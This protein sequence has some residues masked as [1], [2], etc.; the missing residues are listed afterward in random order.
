MTDL[1]SDI[2]HETPFGETESDGNPWVDEEKPQAAAEEIK[3]TPVRSRVGTADLISTIWGGV[4]T[5]GLVN[6]GIDPPVGRMM[7]LQAPLAGAKIDALIANTWID[8]LLQP[9]AQKG[10]AAADVLA[11]FAGPLLVA[12]VERNPDAIPMIEPLLRQVV[13]TSLVEMAPIL[14]KKQRDQ[15]RAAQAMA[16]VSEAFDIPKDQNVFDS[17]IGYIFQGATPPPAANE[18]EEE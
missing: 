3:P 11:I 15:R 4:G 1:L 12:F 16:E 13:E 5:I 6:T 9:L 14:K 18:S 2:E 17:I 10:D 8:G 7:A